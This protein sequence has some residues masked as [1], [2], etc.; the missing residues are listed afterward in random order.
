MRNTAH[1]FQGIRPLFLK[2]KIQFLEGKL[3]RSCTN[4]NCGNMCVDAFKMIGV[5]LPID[6]TN[7]PWGF[8]ERSPSIGTFGE[9]MKNL[10]S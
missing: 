7:V 10:H 3:S 9:Q 5:S 2:S 1:H 8:E 4:C 6:W